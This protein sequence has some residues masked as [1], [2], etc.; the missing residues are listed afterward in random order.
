MASGYVWLAYLYQRKKETKTTQIGLRLDNEL[1]GTIEKLAEFDK[2]DKMTWIRQAIAD[3][4]D[5]VEDEIKDTANEDYIWLRID[6]EELKN[7]T[8][9]KKIPNDLIAA[10]K[11]S[12]QQIIKKKPK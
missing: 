9:L 10:R 5:E 12:L 1:L 8:G 7:I 4:I 11:E 3:R 2:I 6:E